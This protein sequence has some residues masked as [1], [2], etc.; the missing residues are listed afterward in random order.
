MSR[1][2]GKDKF[3]RVEEMHWMP[4][5][6]IADSIAI[7]TKLCE[8]LQKTQKLSFREMKEIHSISVCLFLT[9]Y[10]FCTAQNLKSAP[11]FSFSDLIKK[12]SDIV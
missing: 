5:I 11:F 12:L 10:I 1:K 4:G 7:E 6:F 8:C 9:V 2:N 3:D